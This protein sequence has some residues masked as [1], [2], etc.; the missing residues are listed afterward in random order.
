MKTSDKRATKRV[1]R[2][3]L[4]DELSEGMAALAEDRHGKRTLRG[5]KLPTF[6]G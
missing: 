5:G 2:R 1:A 4:F 3:N 6:R